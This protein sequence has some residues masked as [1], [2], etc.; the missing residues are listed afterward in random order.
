MAMGFAAS[1]A[2]VVEFKDLRKMGMESFKKVDSFMKTYLDELDLYEVWETVVYDGDIA[3]KTTKE[4]KLVYLINEFLVD[5]SKEHGVGISF[6]RHDKEENGSIYDGVDG[7]FFI[8]D[9]STLYKPTSINKKL[10]KKL[11]FSYESWVEFS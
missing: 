10:R 8:L 9:E 6:Y 3:D 2:V 5:F 4:A 1:T 11:D 7:Y